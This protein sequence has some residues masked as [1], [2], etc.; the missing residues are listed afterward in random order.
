MLE[1]KQKLKILCLDIE[2]RPLTY[3]ISDQPTAEITA[4]ATCWSDDKSSM[5]V[6]L[7]GQ[8]KDQLFDAFEMLRAFSRRYNEADMVT[9]H[10]IRKHDLPIINGALM[11]FGL[12]LLGPKLT[13]DTKLD[14]YSKAG[15][16]ASQ[17]YLADLFELEERKLHMSQHDWRSANRL[18]DEGIKATK[19]RVSSDVL[20][21]M[22]MRERML[23]LNLLQAPKLW[24]G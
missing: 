9:G 7:L 15:I 23:E 17:E 20:T 18:T 13:C 2:N 16:P 22:L 4:I 24:K 1:T 5:E 12:P 11:E 8:T 10:Y 3:W 21:H 14:M 19:S 6:H